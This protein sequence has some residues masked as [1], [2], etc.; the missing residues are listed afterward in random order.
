M[1]RVTTLYAASAVATAAYYT[2]YLA[3]AP[4]EAPGRWGG[5]QAGELGLNGRVDTDDLQRL[6]EGPRP[7]RCVARHGAEGP[8]DGGRARGAGGRWVRRHLL[9]AEVGQRLVGPDR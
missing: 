7:D 8:A 9:G 6:L 3:E 2:R 4:G 5:R 1:L